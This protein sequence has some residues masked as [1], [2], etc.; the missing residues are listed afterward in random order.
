MRLRPSGRRRISGFEMGPVRIAWLEIGRG[1]RTATIACVEAVRDTVG[2]GVDL[3]IDVHG[4][5]N[6]PTAIAIARALERYD[7]AWI[8]EPTPPE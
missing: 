6:V 5:L 2:P 7:L 3:M 4:R 8:E 1:E